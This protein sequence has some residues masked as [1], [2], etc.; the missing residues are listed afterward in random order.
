MKVNY[1]LARLNSEDDARAPILNVLRK[2]AINNSKQ[3]EVLELG[4][5][6]GRNLAVFK[7]YAHDVFGI[8]GLQD[9]VNECALKGIPAQVHNLANLI[10]LEGKW[11]LIMIIDVL[12][13]LE[14]PQDLLMNV[15]SLMSDDDVLLINV[16]NHFTL[17]GRIRILFGSGI[18]SERFFPESPEW[19][20][21]HLRFFT[22]RG[23]K[24]L[25]KSSGFE[26]NKDY[27]TEL[28]RY[29]SLRFISNRIIQWLWRQLPID[30]TA[31]GFFIEVRKR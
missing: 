28:L 25:L 20:Y 24:Q 14:N 2:I 19:N 29:P 18:D 3:L 9:A 10:N 31:G 15:R 8:D 12:E 6:N 30:L 27:S 17:Q 11:D 7:E 22:H 5:G 16:P 21:P 13:H 1:S 4:C 23:V 26:L